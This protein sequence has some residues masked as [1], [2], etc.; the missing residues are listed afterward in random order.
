MKKVITAIVAV[1]I[2]IGFG[3]S[4][5]PGGT[6][7]DA[8][9]R[10]AGDLVSDQHFLH[11]WGEL[12]FTGE[13]TAGLANAYLLTDNAS[14][15][16]A[17]DNS[18]IYILY[19]EGGYNPGNG[20]YTYGLFGGGA[21]GLTRLSEI[22]ATPASNTWRTAVWDFYDDVQVRGTQNHIDDFLSNTKVSAAVYDLARHTV[23][24]DYVNAADKGIWRQ[25]LISALENLDDS[26]DSPVMALGAA[27]W[28]LASTGAMNSTLVSS[29]AGSYFNNVPLSDLPD[30]LVGHQSVGGS[31][32]TKFSH[33]LGWG[34]TEATAMASLGML[35]A[36]END[37]SWWYVYEIRRARA[38]LASGVADD[39]R[40]F[41]KIDDFSNPSSYYLA[42]ETLEVL[43]E[44]D[45][46]G[47][48]DGDG[49]VDGIDFGI[50]QTGYYTA[51]GASL[52]DGDA[53][54]DGDVDG[55]DFA[56]WQAGFP[57]NIP[58]VGGGA[59]QII[60]E[61]ATLG[62]LL[63]GG[64][65][66]L[67][68]RRT[69]VTLESAKRNRRKFGRNLTGAL[70]VISLLCTLQ[71]GQA[72]AADP[73]REDFFLGGWAADTALSFN[74]F[75]LT[76][77]VS[78]LSLTSP[79]FAPAVG[80][81]GIGNIGAPVNLTPSISPLALT[82]PAFTPTV[83]VAGIG[84][85]NAPVD[86]TTTVAPLALIPPVVVAPTVEAAG[87]PDA[88]APPAPVEIAAAPVELGPETSTTETTYFSYAPPPRIPYRAPMRSPYR[89]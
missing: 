61:P 1:A 9:N 89:P 56:I 84:T 32:Y 2:F 41:W 19:D 42:G 86:L 21:Y 75:S 29:D 60:P 6:V 3:A 37:P 73:D 36:Y 79:A 65:A 11:D 34:Y 68:R 71:I 66:L 26:H 15:K 22:S 16:T 46:P 59:L 77:S 28:G 30:M 18:G 52:G 64:L 40:V 55:V 88:D 38:I 8:I 76:T 39:G 49:D 63:I 33:V 7:T 87:I 50:W 31:F 72:T 20:Q 10:A 44:L 43:R 67:R 51:S 81:T 48:F 69:K 17:A 27:V 74:P 82:P 83:D 4:A 13:S 85:A 57:T 70:L 25:G 14:Y 24:A 35:A 47:D 12:P 53:D 45:V 80:S 62:L 58:P 23:A 78:R 54:G 5:V